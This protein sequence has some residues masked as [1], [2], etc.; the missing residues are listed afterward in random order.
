MSDHQHNP[1]DQ[2][3]SPQVTFDESRSAYVATLD[4]REVGVLV[5]QAE[6]DTVVMPHTEVDDSAEGSGVGSTL[7]RRA[8]DDAREAGRSVEPSCPFV[9]AW[10]ERHEDY[11]DLVADGA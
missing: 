11:Q 2:Q 5:A 1:H 10:I 8:L 6:G 7:A 3:S 9:A 4:G